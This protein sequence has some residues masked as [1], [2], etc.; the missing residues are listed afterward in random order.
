MVVLYPLCFYLWSTHNF[1]SRMI[2]VKEHANHEMSAY[3]QKLVTSNHPILIAVTS[4]YC[5]FRYVSLSIF[6]F[7]RE[8]EREREGG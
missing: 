2:N 3:M 7:I 4:H 6:A 1:I 5:T 8:R